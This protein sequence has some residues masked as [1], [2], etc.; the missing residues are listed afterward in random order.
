MARGGGGHR[1]IR[2]SGR[3]GPGGEVISAFRARFQHGGQTCRALFVHPEIVT[4]KR[5]SNRPPGGKVFLIRPRR[6][7]L[8]GRTPKRTAFPR[9]VQGPRPHRTVPASATKASARRGG[10]HLARGIGLPA[11][12]GSAWRCGRGFGPCQSCRT[13][14][15]GQDHP[16][17]GRIRKRTA[18]PRPHATLSCRPAGPGTAEG[19]RPPVAGRA[20]AG[21]FGPRRVNGQRGAVTGAMAPANGALQQIFLFPVRQPLGLPLFSC[22]D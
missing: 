16:L 7:W 14:R 2:C 13:F 21:G 18:F 6:A 20:L 5:P 11:G 17:F 8:S 15:H 22:R 19:R 9:P 12:L 4:G 3:R 1:A 10:G